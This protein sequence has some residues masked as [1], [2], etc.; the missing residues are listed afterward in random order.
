MLDVLITSFARITSTPRATPVRFTS[1]APALAAS[2]RLAFTRCTNFV[3]VC[4]D[5]LA[6]F[7]TRPCAFNAR[8]CTVASETPL[9][10]PD[11]PSCGV[12]CFRLWLHSDAW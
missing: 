1:C 3:A 8:R 5:R 9:S 11:A 10:I 7:G 12:V 6:H 4:R 2:K